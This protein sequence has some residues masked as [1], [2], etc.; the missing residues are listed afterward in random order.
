MKYLKGLILVF[1]LIIVLL[2]I[3]SGLTI[4]GYI[5]NLMGVN[6]PPEPENTNRQFKFNDKLYFYDELDLVGTYECKTINCDYAKGTI[7]D[8]NYSINYYSNAKETPIKFIS[9]RY[10]FLVD[11]GSDILLYD[12]LNKSIINKFKAVK[13]YELGIT[14]NYYIVQD[15]NNKWGV[16]KL[17]STAGLVINYKYEFIGIHNELKDG[18]THLNGEIF[19]VKDVNGWKLVSDTDVDKS[20]YYINQIYD[21]NNDYVITKKDNYYYVNSIRSGDLLMSNL[22]SYTKF[23]GRFIAVIDSS[24]DYYLL[25]PERLQ[26]ASQKYKVNTADEVTLEETPEGITIT[27]GGEYKEIV[28]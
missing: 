18:T 10:A 22:F 27:V 12:I 14:D 24:N 5:G 11:D 6:K 1:V 15:M 23:I 20:T 21:Y 8:S 4:W 25:D 13:N 17:D 26:A 19:V 3:F 7:D 2:V 9:R 16:L 28:K